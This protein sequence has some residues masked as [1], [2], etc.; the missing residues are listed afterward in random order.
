MA[1][2][3]VQP[4]HLPVVPSSRIAFLARRLRRS[5][6]GVIGVV[7]VT[8][9]L[10]AA[11]LAPVIAPHE[12]VRPQ[13]DRRLL[14]PAFLP[15]AS[16]DYLLGTDNLGRDIFSRVL[17]GSRVSVV[18]GVS[19]VSIACVIGV[20]SGMLAGFHGGALDV[21]TGRLVDTFLSIPFIVLALAI[22]GVLGP[23]LVNLIVVLGVVGW[24][25]FNRVV[26]GET[27]AIA[28][29]EFVLAARALGQTNA[30]IL[31][32]HV[33][34]NVAPSV[35]VLA[36]LD[37]ASTIIAESA[38][39]FLG[40]GVQHPTVTW[41]SMLADG[42]QYVATAWWL[43]VAPGLAI[44]VTVLGIIFLGDWLRDVLDPRLR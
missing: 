1:A 11:L 37:V 40:L 21:V 12:P 35:I 16:R 9:V 17:Y 13:F 24:V 10:L 2:E 34:P 14:P 33:L 42:R 7:I 28:A 15:G 19:A 20:T 44:T 39:S 23:S 26:R 18:V 6:V 27:I 38:L 31:R 41:G 36:T 22:V 5:P 43:A 30:Q 4:I 25:S 29:R 3:A 32:R 8:A